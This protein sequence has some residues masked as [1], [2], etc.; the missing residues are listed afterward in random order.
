MAKTRRATG[1]KIA[2]LTGVALAVNSAV[3]NGPA[4]R[5]GAEHVLG[6]ATIGAAVLAAVAVLAVLTWAALGLG[7]AR[8]SPDE[9]PGL[10]EPG[11]TALAPEPAVVPL[12]ER[13]PGR[14]LFIN[15]SA[16]SV[17]ASNAAADQETAR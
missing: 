16:S 7:R 12:P 17:T 2:C 11:I 9:A 10:P 5:R 8:R 1:L 13:R 15:G 4:V 14:P 3:R 6:A